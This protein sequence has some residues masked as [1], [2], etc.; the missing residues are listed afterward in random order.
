MKEIQKEKKKKKSEK[1]K[2][3]ETYHAH[4]SGDKI[5]KVSILPKLIDRS[6]IISIQISEMIFD[7]Q[8]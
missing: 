7:E 8:N 5:S 1:M 2:I 6:I 3:G 4:R